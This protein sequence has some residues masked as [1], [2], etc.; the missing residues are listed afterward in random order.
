LLQLFELQNG[1][2]VLFL[3]MLDPFQDGQVIPIQSFAVLENTL[4]GPFLEAFNDTCDDR[5]H[6]CS[7]SSRNGSESTHRNVTH[8][9]MN[10]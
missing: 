3:C 7:V 5:I 2:H 6:L 9:K 4:L 8:L 1:V 10:P